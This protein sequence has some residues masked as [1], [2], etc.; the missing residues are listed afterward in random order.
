MADSRRLF[1]ALWP[2]EPVRRALFRARGQLDGFS[3]RPTHPQDLHITLVF[4]GSV[5]AERQMCVEA[6]AGKI[7]GKPF[8]LTIDHFGFW[9]RPRILWCGPSE[10]PA[11]L[12][13]LVQYLQKGLKR[14]GFDPERRPYAAHAT[15]A[16]KARKIHCPALETPVQWPVREFA[17]VS[18][19]SGGEPPRYEP[20]RTWRFTG[21]G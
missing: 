21:G 5:S 19:R 2:N 16:R 7:R 17:L 6:V 12:Q 4:L 1:F 20:L 8:D 3:G 14:C 15:L 9:P 13:E 18:S 11:A 10:T